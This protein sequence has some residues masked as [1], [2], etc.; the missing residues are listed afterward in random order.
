MDC[1]DLEGEDGVEEG[2]VEGVWTSKGV[3]LT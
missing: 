2:R 1:L 3:K